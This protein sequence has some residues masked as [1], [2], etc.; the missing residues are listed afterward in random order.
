MKNSFRALTVGIA[1]L[2]IIAVT[3]GIFFLQ[4]FEKTGIY[5]WALFFVLLSELALFVGLEVLGTIQS[6]FSKVF[7]RSGIFYVLLLYFLITIISCLFVG[8]FKDNINTFISIEIIII[9]IT[10]ILT[11]SIFAFSHRIS[12]K[13][14][15]IIDDRKFMSAC[16][17]RICNLL[18]V[19]K[20]GKFDK[21]LNSLYESIRYCDKIGSSSVDEKITLQITKL[22]KSLKYSDRTDEEVNSAFDEI[23]ALLKQ[24]N[25]EIL[26]TKRGGF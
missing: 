8:K 3:L 7:V 26:E 23:L 10:A 21:R 12:L 1:G 15:K 25:A 17:K 9:A 6:N 18:A 16:Q 11:L 5:W 24:R 22:E 4:Q 13:D 2:S 19:N 14:K 20:N